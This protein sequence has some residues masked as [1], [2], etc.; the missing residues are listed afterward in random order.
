MIYD[1]LKLRNLLQGITFWVW[2][3]LQKPSNLISFPKPSKNHEKGQKTC[4]SG[5]LI[6][7]WIR[8][9]WLVTC[10]YKLNPPCTGKWLSGEKTSKNDLFGKSDKS[11]STIRKMMKMLFLMVFHDLHDFM[12][13]VFEVVD[14]FGRGG[15]NSFSIEFDQLSN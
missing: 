7:P 3:V 15:F 9:I 11:A 8:D 5:Y 6:N 13:D 2:G 12:F 14:K 1:N 10:V 4:F